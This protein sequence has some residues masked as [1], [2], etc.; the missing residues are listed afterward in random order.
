MLADFPNLPKCRAALG[1]IASKISIATPN[2]NLNPFVVG[3]CERAAEGFG[4][5]SNPTAALAANLFLTKRGTVKE[6][7]L[8]QADYM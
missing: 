5:K 2:S 1:V 7:V 4:L 8:W 6:D 3:K